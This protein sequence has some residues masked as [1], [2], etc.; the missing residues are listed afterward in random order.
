MNVVVPSGVT[1]GDNSVVAANTVL[2]RDVPP[3]SLVYQ[4]PELIVRSGYTTGLQHAQKTAN[5]GGAS[6]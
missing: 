6:S 2:R 1:I 3:N 5:G 4:N